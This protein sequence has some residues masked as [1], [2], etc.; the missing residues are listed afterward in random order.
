MG[1]QRAGRWGAAPLGEPRGVAEAVPGAWPR[2]ARAMS[3]AAAAM[4]RPLA[5]PEPCTARLSPPRRTAGRRRRRCCRRGPAGQR[6][7]RRSAHGTHSSWPSLQRAAARAVGPLPNLQQRPARVPVA[8]AHTGMGRPVL[9][10]RDS[11]LLALVAEGRAQK[12]CQGGKGGGGSGG[13]GRAGRGCVAL[14]A[15]LQRQRCGRGEPRA[16]P[17]APLAPAPCPAR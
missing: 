11:M 14:A 7:R 13:C 3:G 2:K 8:G 4:Q 5:A 15:A 1:R 6:C 10:T 17:A 16:G 9:M 12:S